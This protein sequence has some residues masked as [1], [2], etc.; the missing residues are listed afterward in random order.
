MSSMTM[1][2][3]GTVALTNVALVAYLLGERNKNMKPPGTGSQQ[4]DDTGQ[5]NPRS[6]DSATKTD[7]AP[8]QEV[9]PESE[10]RVGRSKFDV[11]EFLRKFESL[12]QGVIKLNR[13]L[14]RLEGD[15]RFK[16]VEFANEKDRPSEEEMARDNVEN[17]NQQETTSEDANDARVPDDRLDETFQDARIEDFEGDMVSSPSASGSTIEDIEESC[18]TVNN[19][20]ATPEQRK[21]AGRVLYPLLD[22]NL[23][24][25]A[26]DRIRQEVV[27]C[28]RE[29]VRDGIADKSQKSSKPKASQESIRQIPDSVPSKK[30]VFRVPENV[31]DF[32]PEDLFRK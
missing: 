22:T 32:N 17:P 14:D 18:E 7:E 24:E 31:D 25:K 27:E 26:A 9:K 16:D 20:N 19:P 13:T 6:E 29:Y 4:P 23:L 5:S 2:L 30:K 3:L 28:F 12:E 11:D 1:F 8:K 21:K 10:T 15:V